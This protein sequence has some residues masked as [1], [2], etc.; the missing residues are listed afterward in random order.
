MEEKKKIIKAIKSWI[1]CLITALLVSSVL[2]TEVLAGVKVQQNSMENTL[3]NDEKLMMDKLS[4]KFTQPKRGDIIIFHEGEGKESLQDYTS[5]FLN[6]IILVGNSDEKSRLVKRVIGIAGDEVNI[7]DGCVYIND[8]KID[9][10]Y[11]KG[12]TVNR[13]IK[14]PVI[15]G[16]NQLFV[17]GDNRVVSKDSR[18]FGLIDYNQVEGK[19][20]FRIFP[21]NKMGSLK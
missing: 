17:L 16:E 20:I 9:E 11:V 1:L 21:F 2:K 19:V 5:E 6:N 13:D 15:V 14:L 3:Y 18:T 10:S 8:E 7:K 4:Y 12:E